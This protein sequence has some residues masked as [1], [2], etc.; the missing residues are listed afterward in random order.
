MVEKNNTLELS[1][2][3]S[4][5]VDES[6]P[7]SRAIKLSKLHA[8]HWYGYQ[9]SLPVEGNLVLA[10]VTGSGK[11]ILMDLLMLVLVGPEKARHHFNRSATGTQ[12][13][14]TIKGYC[15]LDTKREENGQPT[16]YHENG[17]VSYLAAEF[18][19]PDGKRVE[20]WGLRVEFKST[21]EH[22]GLI[23]AFYCPKALNKEDFIKLSPEDG[24]RHTL[25]LPLFKAMLE[26]NEGR[27]F[28][29]TREYLKE[30]ASV[31][32]LNFGREILDRL[33]PSAMSFTNLKSF[34][35]FC[36][37][38]V[39]PNE[40]VV[41]DDVV[42]SY[43][44]FEAYEK[45]LRDL[46]TQLEK[47]HLI[48]KYSQELKATEQERDV[49][50]YLSVELQ[51]DHVKQSFLSLEQRLEKL[52]QLHNEDEVRLAELNKLLEGGKKQR[53]YALN[54]LN[55]SPDG[56]VY[57]ELTQQIRK[58]EVDVDK[59]RGIC[60]RV[61]EQ[62]R[63]RLDHAK[64][65]L[66]QLQKME[67]VESVDAQ[68]LEETIESLKECEIQESNQ[69]LLKMQNEAEILCQHLRKKMAPISE[70][71]RN[72]KLEQQ[73]LEQQIA[74]LKR[75]LPPLH[76]PFLKRLR[77]EI[78]EPDV[79][80]CLR[81]ICEI[82]D[83]EWR[84]AIE[85]VFT[86]KFSV[87]VEDP[88]FV[89]ALEIYNELKPG[90]GALNLVPESLLNIKKIKVTKIKPNSLAEKITTENEVARKLVDL[91]FGELICVK[92]VKELLEHEKAIHSSGLMHSER[93]IRWNE[94]YD[95]MPYLG[96]KGLERQWEIKNKQLFKV[97][98]SL[99]VLEPKEEQYKVILQSKERNLPDC[100]SLCDDIVR[101]ENMPHLQDQ[102][103]ELMLK[104]Q[105]INQDSLQTLEEQAEDWLAKIQGWDH[106]KFEIAKRNSE[107]EIEQTQRMLTARQEEL[108][109]VNNDFQAVKLKIDISKYLEFYQGRK[110]EMLE[111]M[112]VADAAAREFQKISTDLQAATYEALSQI[113]LAA[114]SF[115][116]A[117]QPRFDDLPE[118]GY[119]VEPYLKLLEKIDSQDIPQ[120]EKKAVTQ[121]Q[122]AE[123]LF[124]TQILSRMH[125]ALKQVDHI[126]QL[127]NQQLRRPIGHD[128]YRIEKR[129]NPEYEHFRMLI[130]LNA[131]VA[132]EDLFFSQLQGELQEAMQLFQNTL[133]QDSQSPAA[134]KLLDYRQYYDYDLIVTDIRDPEARPVSVDKQS[135]KMSGG[136]NQS[137]YFVAILASY[138]HAYNRHDQRS[139]D[140]SLAL[141]PIDEAFSK[142]SGERIQDC[143]MAMAELDLQGVFSMSSGNIPFTFKLCDELIV[144]T[145]RE[146]KV[147]QRTLIRNVPTILFRNTPEGE[148]WMNEHGA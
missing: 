143:L 14:R 42:A 122:N 32:H 148:A 39:L 97:I 1:A 136:E 135:G 119:E 4:L 140:P 54:M 133:I 75:G 92:E 126:I 45:E 38:F 94:D 81:E 27:T 53:E 112:I 11:S 25:S 73:D 20:T 3:E 106:E 117:F 67:E 118:D 110:A 57:H 91:W 36:R 127:L 108:D 142:L 77:E 55:E 21:A 28:A 138:L 63:V 12:S 128:R 141:V 51:C 129:K 59:L 56:R 7:K 23:T 79:I 16:Y 60:M 95:G 134:Q 64:Q 33:L 103:D 86:E 65:W 114:I 139:M 104:L 111:K 15:L 130:D 43:R 98:E 116:T 47:L 131:K 19:W 5:A 105:A 6:K 137:P 76:Q 9:D 46:R 83:E 132:E 121:K 100:N 37:R 123:N 66:Q 18:T 124:R 8:I 17:V 144:I 90:L 85:T 24:M 96:K 61:D 40:G 35:D 84:E 145:K 44:D 109:R 22:D 30:M 93:R 78:R 41:V 89:K 52:K 31:G 71:I 87:Y 34:D 68:G 69:L 107:R 29:S 113:K 115:K 48:K 74:Q 120:Y 80:F 147:N 49:S 88:Y 72:L 70:Q 125:L 101:I 10:G 2:P 102:H 62:M 50:K 58:L 82:K 99:R 146:S 26:Q 13:D